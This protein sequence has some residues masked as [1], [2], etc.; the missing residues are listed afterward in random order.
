[1]STEVAA[2]RLG[3]VL[4]LLRPFHGRS[5]GRTTAIEIIREAGCPDPTRFFDA[6]RRRGFFET[7]AGRHKV[8]VAPV[9]L[10][11]IRPP[12]SEKTADRNMRAIFFGW[13]DWLF[14]REKKKWGR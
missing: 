1:M 3:A 11:E 6:M 2:K 10:C 5:I 8:D 7:N 14:E 4:A 12:I 13:L 9:D